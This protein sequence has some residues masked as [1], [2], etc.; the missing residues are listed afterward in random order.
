[1]K[2]ANRISAAGAAMTLSVLSVSASVLHVSDSFPLQTAGWSGTLSVPQ[3]DPVLG[4]LTGVNYTLTGGVSGNAKAENTGGTASSIELKLQATITVNK[5]GGGQLAQAIPL[6][7]NFFSASAFDNVLDFGGTSGVTY[8]GLTASDNTTG[9]VSA[10]DWGAW[11]GTGDVSLPV[12]S[13]GASTATGGGDI[14]SAFSTKASA[15]FDVWYTYTPVPEPT[16]L[17]FVAGLGLLGFGAYR[18]FRKV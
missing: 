17:A 11:E 10:V 6:A 15:T 13:A 8:S 1:M 3:F 16:A 12:S 4:T 14:T 9:S 7:D 2:I 5:P 18:R